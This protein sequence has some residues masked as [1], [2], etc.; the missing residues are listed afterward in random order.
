MREVTPDAFAVVRAL[1]ERL[2][3]PLETVC[4]G[5]IAPAEAE[6]EGMSWEVFCA[7]L[8]RVQAACGGLEA[9]RREGA[10]ALAVPQLGAALKILRSV[11]G[12][13][14]LMWANFRWGGPN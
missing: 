2:G 13:R 7:L 11:A 3:T 6:K 9:L 12:V 5:I 1:S 4:L 10:C 14:G 8:D